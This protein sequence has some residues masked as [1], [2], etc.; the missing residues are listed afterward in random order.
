MAMTEKQTSGDLAVMWMMADFCALR[1][2][3]IRGPGMAD[4]HPGRSWESLLLGSADV[5][6]APGMGSV[7]GSGHQ[8]SYRNLCRG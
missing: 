5:H 1:G 6:T 8:V 3:G 2:G 4:G 7:G